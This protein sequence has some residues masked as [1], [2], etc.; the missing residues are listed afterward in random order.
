MSVHTPSSHAEN[1]HLPFGDQRSAPFYGKDIL[2]VSQFNR[3]DL[4]Y[5][6]AVAHEMR[7]MVERVGTF[8]LFSKDRKSLL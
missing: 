2:S 1:P 6:F 7:V 3:S 4:D 5:I 8:D